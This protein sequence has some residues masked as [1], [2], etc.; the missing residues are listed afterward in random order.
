MALTY[1]MLITA[2][3]LSL[4]TTPSAP[5]VWLATSGAALAMGSTA[6]VAAPT[7]GK[8]SDGPQPQLLRRLL[9][10]DRVRLLGALLAVGGAVATAV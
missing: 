8:L 5:G 3:A 4:F 6:L 9:L 10:A 2:C 1:G 7:H